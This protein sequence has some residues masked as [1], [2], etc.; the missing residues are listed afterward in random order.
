MQTYTAAFHA[1]D[2]AYLFA[3]PTAAELAALEVFVD[4]PEVAA[5]APPP[6]AADRGVAAALPR[7]PVM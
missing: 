2:S 1:D 6:A 4:A 3:A 5:P 7:G